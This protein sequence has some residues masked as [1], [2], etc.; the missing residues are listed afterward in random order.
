MTLLVG[1]VVYIAFNP[2]PFLFHHKL[3]YIN[4]VSRALYIIV[5]ACMLC[6][7]RIVR[8]PTAPDR[9]VAHDM[10]GVM[11]VGLCA[12]LTV[13]TGR[14]WYIDL[15]IAWA[16]QSFISTLAFAKYLEGKGFED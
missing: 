15:G 11:V 5:M 14:T 13:T 7:F 3:P 12:V 16:L 10:L 4:F 2:L 8:G 1:F 9:I 6:L